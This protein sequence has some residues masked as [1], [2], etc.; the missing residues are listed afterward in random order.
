MIKNKSK[1]NFKPK[2]KGFELLSNKIHNDDR[3][4]FF[5]TYKKKNFINK[6]H[7]FIQDN[8]SRSKKNVLRGMHYQINNPQAQI[9]TVFYGEIF[10]VIV[11]LRINSKTFGSWSYSILSSSGKYN[12]AYMCPGLAHGFLVLSNYADVHYKV[13]NYYNPKNEFGLIWNDEDV[14]IKWPIK[15]PL[16]SN[17][18]KA[19]PK[20]MELNKRLLPRL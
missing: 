14:S 18:D 4:L 6:K 5:E 16:L 17:K 8:L 7:E 1:N 2:I 9:V 10:D 19:H 20:L 15:K 13:T 3:G 12:Q 11:D